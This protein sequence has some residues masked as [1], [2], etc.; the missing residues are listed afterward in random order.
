[1]TISVK[2]ENSRLV[3]REDG[4]LVSNGGGD[5]LDA[6][7]N[8]K[9]IFSLV[10]GGRVRELKTN[11]QF[12]RDIVSGGAVRISLDGDVLKVRKSDGRTEEYANGRCTRSYG[13]TNAP[14]KTIGQ[15]PRSSSKKPPSAAEQAGA[16]AA[17]A[18]MAS[19]GN[20]FSSIGGALKSVAGYMFSAIGGAIKSVLSRNKR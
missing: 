18:L 4:R 3:I 12:S 9:V 6:V 2:V 1:M 15:K 5:F 7:T 20:V 16:A 8:G 19:A 13:D 11:G 17:E 14:R 10:R